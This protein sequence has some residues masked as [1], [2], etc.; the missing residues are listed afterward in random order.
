MIARRLTV[1]V[2]G[3]A[4]S[5]AWTG[6][7]PAVQPAVGT[8]GTH[9]AVQKKGGATIVRSKVDDDSMRVR[10][11]MTEMVQMAQKQAAELPDLGSLNPRDRRQKTVEFMKRSNEVRAEAARPILDVLT[12]EQRTKF[13][14]SLGNKIEVTRL[15]DALIALIP[16]DAEF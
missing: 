2:L 8:Q 12:P 14:K 11:L 1:V 5:L 3:I 7:Q 16:E 9:P 6:C 4:A 15:N 10:L 13:E